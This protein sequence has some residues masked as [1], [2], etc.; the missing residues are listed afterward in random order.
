[1]HVPVLAFD[2]RRAD[3]ELRA[4]KVRDQGT[5]A[6][7]SVDPQEAVKKRGFSDSTRLLTGRCL[8]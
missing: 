5:G 7:S 8:I 1:M 2:F 4:N 3:A 6:G